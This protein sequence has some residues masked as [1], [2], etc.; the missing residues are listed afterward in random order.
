MAILPQQLFDGIIAQDG[1]LMLAHVHP[2]A[3]FCE[4]V[5]PAGT[6]QLLGNQHALL[7]IRIV[8]LYAQSCALQKCAAFVEC[9]V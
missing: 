9:N 8:D 1:V 4:N 3:R 5:Q 6:W 2:A 7:S